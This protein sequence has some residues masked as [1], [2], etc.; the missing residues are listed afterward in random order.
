MMKSNSLFSHFIKI[1][2]L[3][4]GVYLIIVNLAHLLIFNE[5]IKAIDPVTA[6][7]NFDGWH[8]YK[9][10]EYHGF[11]WFFRYLETY[12]GFTTLRNVVDYLGTTPI[13]MITNVTPNPLEILG[14]I[15][16]LLVSPFLFIGAII[17][18]LVSSIIWFFGFILS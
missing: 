7:Y 14:Y 8:S 2:F 10:I 12:P 16:S 4:L 3:T 13:K 18:D 5:H 9:N 15:A 11:R 6:F 1:I 17:F